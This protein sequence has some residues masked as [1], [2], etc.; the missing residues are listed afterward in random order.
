MFRMLSITI[1]KEIKLHL[2][3][4]GYFYLNLSDVPMSWL[5]S[6][7]FLEGKNLNLS[8]V[9]AKGGNNSWLK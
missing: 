1:L 6:N 7:S 3:A 9:I 8:R 5:L 2:T 4:Q